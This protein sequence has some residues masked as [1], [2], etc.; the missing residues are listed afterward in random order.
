MTDIGSATGLTA[1]DAIYLSHGTITDG[2]FIIL[3]V[4]NATESTLESD[5]FAGGGNQT[6][7]SF[8]VGWSYI[9]TIGTAPISSDGPGDQNYFKA[10][11][12]DSGT[13]QTDA[14]DSFWARDALTGSAYIAFDGADFTGQTLG[15]TLFTPALVPGWARHMIGG[16]TVRVSNEAHAGGCARLYAAFPHSWCASHTRTRSPLAA[17]ITQVHAV[18][19]TL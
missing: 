18:A 1:G 3:A 11:V 16:G 8:Q 13:N 14:E 4:V 10:R 12:E 17:A 2:F 19:R 5:P 6:N 15:D 7:I 9:E